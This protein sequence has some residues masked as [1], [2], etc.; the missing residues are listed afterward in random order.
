MPSRS[1]RGRTTARVVGVSRVTNSRT[2][3]RNAMSS[4]D[5]AGVP[6]ARHLQGNRRPVNPHCSAVAEDPAA[7]AVPCCGMM[8]GWQ[9]ERYW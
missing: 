6:G 9:D 3:A 7:G 8:I 1:A 4:L 2:T 5:T